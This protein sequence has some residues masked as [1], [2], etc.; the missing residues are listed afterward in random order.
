MNEFATASV[1]GF[2]HRASNKGK[3]IQGDGVIGN[4]SR[5]FI[6]PNLPNPNCRRNRSLV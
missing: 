6:F 4:T 2:F 5:V 1:K 3:A